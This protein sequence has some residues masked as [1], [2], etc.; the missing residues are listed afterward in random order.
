MWED[1]MRAACLMLVMEGLLP[2]IAPERWR[3]TVAGLATANPA[4]I[5]KVGISCMLL[6]ATALFF[7]HR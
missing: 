6:G 3:Q 5:R 4:T 2:A 7:Y 1:L